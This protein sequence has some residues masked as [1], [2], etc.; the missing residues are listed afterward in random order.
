VAYY[1]RAYRVADVSANWRYVAVLNFYRGLYRSDRL[2]EPELEERYNPERSLFVL[3]GPDD[4]EFIERNGLKVV[5]RG[6]RSGVVVAI[7]PEVEAAPRCPP[8]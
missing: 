8:G 5:Y 6:E 7:R 3:Y 4:R 1:S 2:N